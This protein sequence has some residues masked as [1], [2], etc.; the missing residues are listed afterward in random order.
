[1]KLSWVPVRCRP[2]C[3]PGA[4]LH[5]WPLAQGSAS[6]CAIACRTALTQIVAGATAGLNWM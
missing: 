4:S 6:I 1:M 3:S 2:T 5:V